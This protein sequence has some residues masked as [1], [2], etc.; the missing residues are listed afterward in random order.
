M[1]KAGG[2]MR[3]IN[4]RGW[5]VL[6][7]L[8]L[9][10]GFI[11][12]PANADAAPVVLSGSLEKTSM[13]SG[14]SFYV[15]FRIGRLFADSRSWQS[16]ITV[17]TYDES[18]TLVSRATGSRGEYNVTTIVTPFS[19]FGIRMY[20]WAEATHAL[21][22]V[23]PA[24][25]R[26]RVTVE[27][28]NTYG[29]SG[30]VEIGRFTATDR[31]IAGAQPP[32]ITS[33]SLLKT[34]AFPGDNDI[35]LSATF[36]DDLNCVRSA[37]VSFGEDALLSNRDAGFQ[38][39]EGSLRATSM[40]VPIS[41]V[42]GQTYPISLF[43][44]DC[45]GNRSETRIL[46]SLR[47]LGAVEPNPVDNSGSTASVSPETQANTGSPEIQAPTASAPVPASSSPVPA[48]SPGQQNPVI[49]PA[50][51]PSG[52]AAST[53]SPALPAAGSPSSTA[54]TAS[55]AAGSTSSASTSPI[56]PAPVKEVSP[57]PR[58]VQASMPRVER[59]SAA[60]EKFE[61]A[62]S[63]VL[64]EK[65]GATKIVCTGI[66]FE[67]AGT[68]E[69]IRLRKLAQAACS[70]AKEQNPNLS[71]WFQTRETKSRSSSGRVLV[72]LK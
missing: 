22:N 47:V 46:G 34:E 9:L 55:P 37:V 16:K 67:G 38:L 28:I 31:R 7:S 48:G 23:V 62:I 20:S 21:S 58:F 6:S 25:K 30:E 24:V 56:T 44:V 19:D 57:E 68:S 69:R 18:G 71:A 5:A 54:P 10:T 63:D 59:A 26:Y 50:G 17:R 27:A 15:D 32:V 33:G 42:P 49:P 52:T 29:S 4:F 41:A 53:T 11:A 60:A 43:V 72:T 36:T 39:I 70:V 12:S 2:N 66:F 14:E 40:Y 64:E 8:L 65:P 51:N 13:V 45:E 61:S 3:K 35:E 1:K